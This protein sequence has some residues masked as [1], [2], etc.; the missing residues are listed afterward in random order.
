[1]R[2][3]GGSNLGSKLIKAIYEK[4]EIEIAKATSHHHN[5]AGLVERFNDT[6]CGMVR[7]STEEATA[8]D[9]LLLFCLFAYRSTPHRVTH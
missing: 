2:C 4:S 3:D 7:A 5:L 9:E 8:W 1:M 6:L